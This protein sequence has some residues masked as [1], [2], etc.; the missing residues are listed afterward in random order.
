MKTRQPF[1]SNERLVTPAQ[2]AIGSRVSP[3]LMPACRWL[4]S[5]QDR[6]GMFRHRIGG[7]RVTD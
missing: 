2:V 6:R 5:S 4:H 1:A 7:R 3:F